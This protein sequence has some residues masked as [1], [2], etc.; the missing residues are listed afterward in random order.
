[1]DK[2]LLCGKR[3]WFKW[4]RAKCHNGF[5]WHVRCRLDVL[6]YTEEFRRQELEDR[7]NRIAVPES[8]LGVIR[9]VLAGAEVSLDW[10][11][12]FSTSPLWMVWTVKIRESE[13]RRRAG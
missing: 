11:M 8:D 1:M 4:T 13:L 7:L 9:A 6:E 2:C 5:T 10:K 12:C 3:I